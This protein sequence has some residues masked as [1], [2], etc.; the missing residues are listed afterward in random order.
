[1]PLG[2]LTPIIA[3]ST[4]TVDALAPRFAR[5]GA[6]AAEMLIDSYVDE[7]IAQWRV[8]DATFW[9]RVKFRAR[10]LRAAGQYHLPVG[11]A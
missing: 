11:H 10:M 6:Q 5:L 8:E 3:A 9:Q 4:T 1:M 7:A 2:N